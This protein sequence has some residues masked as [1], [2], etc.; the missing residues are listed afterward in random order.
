MR[1]W[2]QREK[3]PST[4]TL[5]VANIPFPINDNA[6]ADIFQGEGFVSARIVR[7]RNGRSRGYGFVEFT[8]QEFQIKAL[9]DKQ[10]LMVS[11]AEGAEGRPLS[12]SISSSVPESEGVAPQTQ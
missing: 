10:G 1:Q 8:A 11:G 7:T 6:L 5:F 12:I 4:T 2:D 3:V 9:E